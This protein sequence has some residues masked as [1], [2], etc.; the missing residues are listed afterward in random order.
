MPTYTFSCTKCDYGAQKIFKISEYEEETMKGKSCQNPEAPD[1]DGTYEHTFE[2][3]T[4]GF[5]FIG[6]P[7]TPKFHHKANQG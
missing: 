1:C 4:G 7:P 5:T 2:E 6:G 3:R